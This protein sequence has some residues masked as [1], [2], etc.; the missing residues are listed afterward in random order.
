MKELNPKLAFKQQEMIFFFI[1]KTTGNEIKK[2]RDKKYEL[3]GKGIE[4][5]IKWRT[6]NYFSP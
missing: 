2:V 3:D 1:K 5:V 4:E 6:L